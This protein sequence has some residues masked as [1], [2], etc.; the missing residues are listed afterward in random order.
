MN[1]RVVF[2]TLL[3]TAMLVVLL[4]AVLLLRPALAAPRMQEGAPELTIVKTDEGDGTIAPGD[5]VCFTIIVTNTGTITATNVTVRDDYDQMA[6]PTI[7][8]R[9][10]TC[11]MRKMA[12]TATM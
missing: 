9:V 4:L 12:M 7:S 6:L 5:T 11:Q 1:K 2:H 10:S 3:G 8:E